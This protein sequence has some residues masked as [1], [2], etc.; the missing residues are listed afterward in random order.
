VLGVPRLARLQLP[1]GVPACTVARTDLGVVTVLDM[2]A[3]IVVAHSEKECAAPT[4]KGSF[5]SHPIGV[6]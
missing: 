4:F 1:G 3:T 6:V 2:D 5:G